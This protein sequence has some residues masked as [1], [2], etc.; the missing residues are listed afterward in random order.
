MKD[1]DGA[2]ALQF[3]LFMNRPGK[4]VVQITATDRVSKKSS[5]Y[6]LPVT[7]VPAN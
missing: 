5:V 4:F 7:V 6:K 1:G 2:F 3:P